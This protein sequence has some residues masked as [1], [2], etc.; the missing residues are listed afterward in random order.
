[1]GYLVLLCL[2]APAKPR[3]Q[4]RRSD[5]DLD[6]S[7][8][9]QRS[10]TGPWPVALIVDETFETFYRVLRIKDGIEP[11]GRE[12]LPVHYCN[13]EPRDRVGEI[14]RDFDRSF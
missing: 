12:L 13:A 9:V 11:L 2:K 6:I 1:M 4:T 8:R 14:I 5:F 10:Y 7:A 3:T